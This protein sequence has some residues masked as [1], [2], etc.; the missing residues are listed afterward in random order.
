MTT[1]GW[2]GKI[3]WVDLTSGK[4][5][6]ERLSKQVY[7][8]FV[9]G[10]GLGTYLLYR[11]LDAATDPLGPDNLLLFLTGPLQGLPAPNVGRW[12]LVTK[13]PLTGLYLDTH[14][15]GPLGR[16]IKNSGY[17]AV[18]VRGRSEYPTVLVIEDDDVR[19]EPA[20]DIW[21]R[22][23]QEST[24]ILHDRHNKGSTVFAIGPAGE[25]MV[26][27]ATACCE[28]AHQT[29][30]GGAGAV[31]GSKN[32]KGFVAKGSGKVSAADVDEIRR[33]N[34]DLVKGWNEKTDYGFKDY[35]TPFL[36][37]LSNS[38]GQYPTR[39]W[40]SGYFEKHEG[41]DAETMSREWGL[42]RHHSCPHCVMRCTHAFR[43][44]DPS[45]PGIE[46]E[47]T[48][49]Y[50][51]LGLMGGNLGIDDP[52]GVL[53]LNYLCDDLGMDTISTG[54]IIGFAMEAFEKGIMTEEEI[55][56]SLNFG[57]VENAI[58][59]AK[60]ISARDGIGDVLADGVKK[61]SEQIGKGSESFAVH[62]KGLEV[63]AWDPRGRRGLGI[64]YAT[65]EVGASH[66]RGWPQTLDMPEL[67]A[68]DVM[69]SLI[70]NRDTKILTDSLIV[71]HFTYHLPLEH[72]VKIDL[73]NAATGVNYTRERISRF[74]NRVE[75]LTRLFNIREGIGRADDRIP[76]RFWEK[77]PNGPAKGMAAFLDK[78]D[79]NAALERFYELRG[80]DKEGIPMEE[81]VEQLGLA[82]IV[83][84]VTERQI[85]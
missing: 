16:E 30:R 50:E 20:G 67:P 70:E 63:P 32:L 26:P 65:A 69:E 79:F 71:C 10:K 37:E 46:V 23:T 49:E 11:E 75:T 36:V 34:R 40:Q 17:D 41:L 2:N 62:V 78:D 55:G 6:S 73:L 35:G 48:V 56:F 29:G 24:R 18:G 74:A 39:N 31:L 12:T 77:Q 53:K 25:R 80:W 60:M 13:S 8:D 57:D 5:R 82:E 54:S 15:G 83:G 58:R 45:N 33:I 76:P 27:V 81:T 85:P 68:V 9:G 72:D 66:L 7:S 51:T 59:L 52:Q 64:S 28:L 4:S 21:G 14:C 42:G 38:R 84:E 3:L 43:T 61:A 1:N 44:E 19:L 47:S 22:G